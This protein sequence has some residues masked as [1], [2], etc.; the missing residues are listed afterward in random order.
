M[1][2]SVFIPLSDRKFPI[3][4]EPAADFRFER[5]AA[6]RAELP[7]TVPIGLGWSRPDFVTMCTTR[8]LSCL[9]SQRWLLSPQAIYLREPDGSATAVVS[10]GLGGVRG[11]F[12]PC[13]T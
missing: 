9:A 1:N 11:R 12:V 13:L 7:E 6:E 10:R 8:L 5:R 2:R 3:V 4:C